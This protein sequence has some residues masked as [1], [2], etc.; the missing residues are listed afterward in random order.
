MK[1]NIVS[2]LGVSILL[3]A[4]S[5]SGLFGAP[6]PTPLPT[7][8]FT[9]LPPPK[10]ATAT[11]TFTPSPLPTATW[12]WQGPDIVTIPIFLYHRI[13]TSPTNSQYYV[14]PEKFEEQMRL[15]KEWGYETISTDLL[16]KAI[17]EGASL[18]PR[19]IIITFDDGN[20]N[21]YTAAFPIMQK[22]GFTGVL[23]I[24][25][26]Y[27]GADQFMNVDQIREMA[28]AG[29]EVGSHGMNHKD[30][31]LLEPQEQRSE[32]VDSKKYLENT[33]GVPINTIAYPYGLSDPSV[34]DF[35]YFAGYTA[36]MSLGASQQQGTGNLFTLQ[37]RDIKGTY[38]LNQFAYF[39]PWK[40]DPIYLPATPTSTPQE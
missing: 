40:G 7:T 10:T 27:M 14:P 19:P 17:T 11:S 21:N 2:L 39:L 22:Y 1:K 20:L 25:G 12:V 9:P 31:T 36:G 32:I 23:Y 15:L 26:N 3:L 6:T 18:P 33:L 4:C 38:D 5:G 16:L 35:T 34:I 37:R 13:D 28:A 30:L 8:T 24:V 29:W